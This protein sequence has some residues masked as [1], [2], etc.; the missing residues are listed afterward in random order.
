MVLTNT[1]IK[2]HHWR[3]ATKRLEIPIDKAGRVVLPKEVRDQLGIHEK[4][5]FKVTEES[6]KIILTPIRTEPKI[7]KKNGLLVVQAPEAKDLD[8]VEEIKKMREKRNK[9]VRGY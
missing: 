6:N 4:T 3:V 7:V 2:C 8:I 5:K 1:I 9:H